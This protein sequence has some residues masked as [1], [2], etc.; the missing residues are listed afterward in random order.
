MRSKKRLHFPALFGVSEFGGTWN[1]EKILR[2]EWQV[3]LY[4]I[5]WDRLLRMHI[6]DFLKRASLAKHAGDTMVLVGP[7][8]ERD[9][10]L[11]KTS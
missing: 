8:S 4:N 10:R 1:Q 9:V 7:A 2:L 6:P 5:A 11:Q 3:S